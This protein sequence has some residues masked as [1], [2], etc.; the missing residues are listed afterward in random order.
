MSNFEIY[1]FV[2]NISVLALNTYWK[3]LVLDLH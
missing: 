1:T 2:L 3:V